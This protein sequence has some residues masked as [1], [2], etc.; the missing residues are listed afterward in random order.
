[1]P[2]HG[3]LMQFLLNSFNWDKKIK[4]AVLT[5]ASFMALC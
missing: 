1:M 2:A 4:I 3:G 5:L